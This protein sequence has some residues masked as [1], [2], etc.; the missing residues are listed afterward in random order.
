MGR[1]PLVR[2]RE[3]AR[4]LLADGADRPGGCFR[5][6]AEDSPRVFWSRL[7]Q[8]LLQA[9]YRADLVNDLEVAPEVPHKKLC[10]VTPRACL[11]DLGQGSDS[12]SKLEKP[13][14]NL[15][16]IVFKIMQALFLSCPVSPARRRSR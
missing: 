15:L 9:P 5:L 6:L 4:Q 8:L 11:S 12:F 3:H 16:L 2:R 1:E 13:L 7:R 14:R 10:G